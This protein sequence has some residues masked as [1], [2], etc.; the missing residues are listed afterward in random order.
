MGP[1]GPMVMTL[2]D[3]NQSH[4][5]SAEIENRYL[6]LLQSQTSVVVTVKSANGAM[7]DGR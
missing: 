4:L 6:D 1:F 7:F 3:S 5:S 2:S